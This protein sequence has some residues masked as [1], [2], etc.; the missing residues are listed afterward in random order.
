MRLATCLANLL[1]LFV[2]LN[3]VVGQRAIRAFYLAR[4]NREQHALG[5][6]DNLFGVGG[7]VVGQRIDL[8]GGA[9]NLAQ[10][11]VAAHDA[12]VVLPSS[13]RIQLAHELDDVRLTTH[14]L[15]LVLRAQIV[16]EGYGVDRHVA[17]VHLVHRNKDCLVC[18]AVE[19]VRLE[20]YQRFLYHLARIEHSGK[21]VSL[22]LV[23]IG[24]TKLGAAL[25]DTRRRPCVIC[26]R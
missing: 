26:G 8:V 19:I 3:H 20:L 7:R 9:N 23:V 21:N 10:H 16:H 18:R 12:R 1:G 5:T 22:G 11:G 15:E 4:R 25:L 17:V 6:L 2:G 24:Q 14:R 13:K